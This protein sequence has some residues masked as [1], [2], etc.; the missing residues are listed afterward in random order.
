[1]PKEITLVTYGLSE[2]DD[3]VINKCTAVF[4]N[5]EAPTFEDG[6]NE[7]WFAVCFTNSLGRIVRYPRQNWIFP[8]AK[9]LEQ[10]QNNIAKFLVGLKNYMKYA[11]LRIIDK[12]QCDFDQKNWI[13]I[14][15]YLKD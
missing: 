14:E 9:S 11:D 8:V 6:G 12:D 15:E 10:K 3:T 5:H 2:I 1:M 13:T 7:D 4:K